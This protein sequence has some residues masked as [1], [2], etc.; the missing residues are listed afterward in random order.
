MSH[1]PIDCARGD[2][3]ELVARYLAG[4]MSGPEAEAFEEHF[5]GCEECWAAVRRGVE[6]RAAFQE[7]AGEASPASASTAHVAPLV[8]RRAWWP[9][10]AAAALL[11][12]AVTSWRVMAL[13]HPGATTLDQ[14]RSAG[15]PA[16]HVRTDT[17]AL[18]VTWSPVPSAAGYR[19]RLFT[20]DGSVLLDREVADTALAPS[21][22]VPN[23][24][25][26]A[27]VFWEVDALNGVRD[28]IAR[29]ALTAA[30]VPAA[31]R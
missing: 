24:S 13:H 27:R 1:P 3:H 11:I 23:A 18:A 6:V 20:A 26:G 29:S 17:G 8:R 19:V 16:V 22:A 14:E 25:P 7:P 30:R 9:L 31:P 15:A 12:A 2:R 4:T 21:T 5:F 28:V 10:A